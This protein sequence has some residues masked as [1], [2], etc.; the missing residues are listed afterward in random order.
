MPKPKS[1]DE[2]ITSAP[3]EV[4]DKLI[5]LRQLIKKCAPDATEKISY[6]MPYYG[7]NGRLVYY[8]YAKKHIGVYIMP[9]FLEGYE[10]EIKEYRTGRATL[11]LRLDKK[12][13]EMLITKILKNAVKLVDSK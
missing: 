9:R 10:E 3:E 2:Y 5:E 11:Q 7:Y 6:G 13:P 12:I 1:V 8:A 4:K